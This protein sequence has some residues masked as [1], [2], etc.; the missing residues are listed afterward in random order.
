MDTAIECEWTPDLR[1]VEYDL[2]KLL[3]VKASLKVMICDS[4]DY[5]RDK[6]VP[7]IEFFTKRYRNCEPGETYMIFNWRGNRD[8]ADCHVWTPTATGLAENE[9]VRFRC[10]PGFP[11]IVSGRL[12]HPNDGWLGELD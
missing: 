5:V 4:P 3:H 7:A 2:E 12:P 11:A 8:V 9:A 10:V 6:L 1:S